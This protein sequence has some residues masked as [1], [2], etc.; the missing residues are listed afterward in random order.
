MAPPSRRS[1]S[2]PRPRSSGTQRAGEDLPGARP[3]RLPKFV[4]PQL[5]TLV[6]KAPEG[7]E[8]LHEFKFDG[9]RILARLENGRVR[10]LSRNGRDWT[11]NFPAVA[12]GVARLPVKDA[13]VDGEVAVFLPDGTTSFQALQQLSTGEDA[14]VGSPTSSSTCST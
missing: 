5:A 8:W 9:Y 3:G 13:M 14:A 10:L 4:P 11:A 7:D 1:R 6:E 2:S 12:E